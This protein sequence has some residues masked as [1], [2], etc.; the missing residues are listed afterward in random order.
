MAVLVTGGAG[1][2]GSHTVLE[3]LD[4]GEKV[5]VIDNL[6]NGHRRSCAGGVFYKGDLRDGPFLDEVFRENDIEAVMHFA[7][8]TAV[9]ES[10]SSPLKYYHNNVVSSLTLLE[11]AVEAGVKKMVFSSSAAVYGDPGRLPITESHAARPNNPYG[12]TKLAAERA[13]IWAEGAYG[14][15]HIILRYF[16]AAGAHPGG[17]IGEDHRPETHLI[18]L[19][20]KVALGKSEQVN[21]FGKDYGTPDGTCIR[22][23]IHVSDLARAHLLGLERL[24]SL[25]QSGLYNLGN[26]EGFSNLE[27]VRAAEAVTGGKINVS[28]TCRRPGDPSALVASSRKAREEL[29]WKPRFE[30]LEEI[31]ETAWKW[32][33]RHPDGFGEG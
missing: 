29:G 23:Y 1:Y 3:L 17:D 8:Y 16:N 7:A 5:V 18:P 31:I 24:R 14:V 6:E 10:I 25:N 28:Y 13:L 9:G 11:K 2:I 30:R 19:V 12:D 27:V 32:H 21:I 26:G 15:K 22:D 20:L 33:S 4:R